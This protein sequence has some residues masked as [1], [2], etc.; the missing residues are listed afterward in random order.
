MRKDNGRDRARGVKIRSESGRTVTVNRSSR[1][2]ATS[3]SRGEK[4]ESGTTTLYSSN[5]SVR[6]WFTSEDR[7]D[8]LVKTISEKRQTGETLLDSF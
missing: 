8:R 3:M 5:L 2:S 7:E 4:R 6:D 1:F